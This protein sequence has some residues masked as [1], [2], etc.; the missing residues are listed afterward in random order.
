MNKRLEKDINICRL[1]EKRFATS[2]YIATLTFPTELRDATFALYAFFRLPDE[3]VDSNNEADESFI[4]NKLFLFIEKWKKFYEDYPF[5]YNDNKPSQDL[6]NTEDDAVLRATAYVF[7][8]YNIP[9][10]LSLDFLEAMI[11]DLD[12]N[13]YSTYEDLKKYMFGSAGVVGHMMTYIIG[14]HNKDAFVYAED[15]GYAMQMTNFLRDIKEDYVSRGRIYI[16]E[17]DLLAHGLTY[18]DII[19]FINTGKTDDRWVSYMR[20]EIDRIRNLYELAEKKGV[21]LLYNHGRKSTLIAL[22]LYRDILTQI[23][24]NNYNVFSIRASVPKYRKLLFVFN[25][26]VGLIKK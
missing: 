2:Y 10:K 25:V 23:E 3:I 12:K 22:Y 14:Y 26:M 11:M 16:P 7:H 19:N 5:Y 6:N 4:R 24:K 8:K 15:L 1:V 21:P 20:F 18:Q 17:Q 13:R 9:Y